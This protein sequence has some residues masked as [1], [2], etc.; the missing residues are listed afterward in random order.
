MPIARRMFGSADLGG[1]RWRRTCRPFPQ[2]GGAGRSDHGH[3][4][5]E[6]D[7]AQVAEL[8]PG[9]D[10]LAERWLSTRTSRSG[11]AAARAMARGDH[12][13]GVCPVASARPKLQLM[14][15]PRKPERFDEGR[16]VDRTEGV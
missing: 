15:V 9:T 6:M 12:S 11:F 7:T 13:R 8:V 1:G 4:L 2:T 3:R 10:E 5:D 16:G 14:I